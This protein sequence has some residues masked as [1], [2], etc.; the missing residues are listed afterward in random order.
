MID[1]LFPS[2]FEKAVTET[3]IKK[4]REITVNIHPTVMVMIVIVPGENCRKYIVNVVRRLWA[5]FLVCQ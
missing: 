2:L 4:R 1:V 3:F 5:S